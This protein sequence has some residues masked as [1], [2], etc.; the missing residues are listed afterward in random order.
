MTPEPDAAN[1]SKTRRVRAC[2]CSAFA[3]PEEGQKAVD[4]FEVEQPPI[5]AVQ[6]EEEFIQPTVSEPAS[7]R[8]SSRDRR[9]RYRSFY[10]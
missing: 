8:G 2:F 4:S 7:F 3:E 10:R 9:N 6:V 5:E 1:E